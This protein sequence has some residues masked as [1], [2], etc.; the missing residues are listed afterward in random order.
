[1]G[2]TA[3]VAAVASAGVKAYGEMKT[4][5]ANSAAD[6]YNAQIADNNAT[7]ATQQA[8][9]EA[10]SGEQQVA[11]KELE[12]RAKVGSIEA[13][14]GAS[15]VEVGTGSNA[16]VVTSTKEIGALDAMTIRSNA[17]KRAYGYQVENTSD[18]AQAELDRMAASDATKAGKIGAISTLLG[19]VAQGSQYSDLMGNN[20]M[21]SSAGVDA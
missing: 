18:R 6:K 1:M 8:N 16:D 19:G 15:G 13:N 9:W 10:E 7:I 17:V 5:Q 20:S 4:A 2:I 14:Q 11:A 3:G 21:F 12:N